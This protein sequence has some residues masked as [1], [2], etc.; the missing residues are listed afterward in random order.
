MV[1]GL[2]ITFFSTEDAKNASRLV[3]LLKEMN[4]VSS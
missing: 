3:E 4:Q 1:H 2:A